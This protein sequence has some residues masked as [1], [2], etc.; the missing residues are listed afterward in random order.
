MSNLQPT[1]MQSFYSLKFL[2]N[3]LALVFMLVGLY[4]CYNMLTWAVDKKLASIEKPEL[5]AATVEVREKQLACLARNIYFE[6]GNE[7]FEGKVAVAQVTLNRADSG[8][9]PTDICRVVY[10]KNI[11]YEKVVCQF[12][13][14]C[15]RSANSRPMHKDIYNECMEV[16]KKV[17]LEGFRLPVLNDAMY[18][19][20]DYVN[21]GWRKEKLAKIGRHIFYR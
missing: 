21:P 10:Q 15:D 5:H 12:S 2:G 20:A 6:A 19:H 14:Y 18:Y 16:A 4:F 13:W 9:F 17:L 11:F 8:N 7:S 3:I 1:D